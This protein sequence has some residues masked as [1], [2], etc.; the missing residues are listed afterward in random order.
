MLRGAGLSTTASRINI[1][2]YWMLGMPFGALVTVKI[3]EVEGLWLGA[4]FALFFT[5]TLLLYKVDT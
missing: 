3:Q 1:F 4:A 5:A 2:S